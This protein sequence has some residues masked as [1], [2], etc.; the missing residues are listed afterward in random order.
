MASEAPATEPAPA[1]AAEDQ[2]APVK[3]PKENKKG[4][5]DSKEERICLVCGDRANGV[6]YNV[7]S[8]EGCK[9]F[10]LRSAKSKAVFTCSQGGTC[11][12]DL[13]TRRHC[14]ACRMTRCKELGMSLESKFH[15]HLLYFNFYQNARVFEIIQICSSQSFQLDKY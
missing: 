1:A 3:S 7:L 13:Y 9:S 14:P 5:V 12:M 2:L 11:T 4:G 15:I 8:C 6:H 10:F